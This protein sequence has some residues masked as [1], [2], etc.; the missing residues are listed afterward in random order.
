M[1]LAGPLYYYSSVMY[2]RIIHFGVLFCF[3]I[4]SY[5]IFKIYHSWF[6]QPS[7]CL[8]APFFYVLVAAVDSFRVI[9]GYSDPRESLHHA[10]ACL[11]DPKDVRMPRKNPKFVLMTRKRSTLCGFLSFLFCP[12]LRPRVIKNIVFYVFRERNRTRQS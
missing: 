2:I 8:H 6:S 9:I 1:N 5:C 10:I 12:R 11:W 3:I 7:A 4:P